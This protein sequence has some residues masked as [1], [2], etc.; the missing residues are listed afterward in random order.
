MITTVISY[1]SL[2]K[3]FIDKNIEECLKFS[4]EVIIVCSTHFLNGQED[5]EIN[6]FYEKYKDKKNVKI[7]LLDWLSDTK[8]DDSIYW[9]NKFRYIGG[10]TSTSD[11]CLFLDA[12]EVP[13][14]DLFE[15]YL[16][17][18]EYKDYDIVA[19]FISYYYFRDFCYRSTT[20]SGVGLLIKK[21]YIIPDLFF[22][23]NE[24]WFYRLVS[25]SVYERHGLQ[26]PKI[27]TRA[28]LVNY[29]NSLKNWNINGQQQILI[30][31]DV[32]FHHYS[33]VRSKDE[34]L[35]K[36]NS[37]GHKYDRDWNKLIEE[38]F[39]RDFNNKCFIHGWE[40]EKI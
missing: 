14:G 11:Y 6:S 8:K 38:E 22:T 13:E 27:K 28:S 25:D 12:D 35:V 10:T 9:H 16:K 7:I 37:W 34:M 17:T 24:R 5:T 30:V 21:S 33:W 1:C 36:V 39:N 31:G 23:Y 3:K 26:K 32:L 15:K 40:Y 19:D 20:L 4:K 2:D 29:K 18:N